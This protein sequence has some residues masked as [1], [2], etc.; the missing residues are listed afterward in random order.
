M[1]TPLEWPTDGEV[2]VGSVW[3]PPSGLV[4]GRAVNGAVHVA[5]YQNGLW[6]LQLRLGPNYPMTRK[7]EVLRVLG[8]IADGFPINMPV[9]EQWEAAPGGGSG[10][11]QIA[12]ANQIG[13]SIDTTGWTDGLVL[14]GGWYVSFKVGDRW[15]MYTMTAD[16]TAVG[17]AASL[18]VSPPV[19]AG[20]SPD[21]GSDIGW[22]RHGSSDETKVTMIWTNT[23]A[24]GART[25]HVLAY[26]Q[27]NLS[28]QGWGPKGP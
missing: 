22:N 14:R 11:V 27:L 23:G 16:A 10:G 18:S 26:S 15:D 20:R 25:T 12:G 8:K 7:R 6:G 3:S 24:F 9:H 21:N 13:T 4:I 19:L 1:A 28:F 17:G 5:D 2:S